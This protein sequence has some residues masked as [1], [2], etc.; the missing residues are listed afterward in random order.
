MQI[1]ALADLIENNP[2]SP[3]RQDWIS[4]YCFGQQIHGQK[5]GTT[6]DY[7]FETNTFILSQAAESVEYCD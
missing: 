6:G 3:Q 5:Y 7:V 2:T 1:E 4:T